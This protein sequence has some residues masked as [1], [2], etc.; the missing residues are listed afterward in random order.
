[1][2]ATMRLHFMLG[3]CLCNEKKLFLPFCSLPILRGMPPRVQIVVFRIWKVV[4][5]LILYKV[6]FAMGYFFME[7][8]S[9]AIAQFYPSSAGGMPGESSPPPGPSGDGS[10]M[11]LTSENP[12][13]PAPSAYEGQGRGFPSRGQ[14]LLSDVERRMELESE[15]Q[16][17]IDNQ[18]I[19]RRLF[20][21]ERSELLTAQFEC[22]LKLE[23][24]QTTLS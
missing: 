6:A 13:E 1:M 10:V 22:E 8:L 16:R 23:D 12:H 15:L 2:I 4:F 11:A 19:A 5:V 7:D 3:V 21:S 14:P 24:F 17:L 20:P 9:R 18:V